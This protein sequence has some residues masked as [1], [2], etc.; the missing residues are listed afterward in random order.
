[1]LPIFSL[2]GQAGRLFKPLAFTKT[3][4]MLSAALLSI[5]FAP[6]LRDLL[7]RGRIRPE[8]RPPVSRFLIAV[9]T[10]LVYVALPRP[11][12]TV[13]IGLCAMVSAVPLALTLGHE[14]MPPLDE[15]DLLYMPITFPGISIEQAKTEL[16]RQDRILHGFPEGGSVVGKAGRAERPTDPAPITMVE[17]TVRLRPKAEWRKKRVPRWYSSW[18]PG[19]VKSVLAPVWPEARTISREELVAEMNRHL[20][21]P[22]WTNAWTMPIKTRVDMLSTGIRT[23]IGVKI[24]GTDLAEIEKVGTTLERLLPPIRGTRSVIHE[25][26]LG[27][28]YLDIIPDRDPIARHGRTVG[29]V[30]RTIEAA[31][32]GNPIGVTIEGRN[33]FTV[34]V[35]YPQDL[36][37]DVDRLKRVVVGASA[38]L[39]QLADVRIVGGPPMLRDEGGLLTGYVYIDIDP[40]E[41][42]IGGRAADT[43]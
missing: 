29:D 14:F 32:G 38:P 30:E 2:T 40:D 21:I 37:D 8:S 13:A 11:Q 7:I 16:Q 42:D 15:G 24:Y 26:N 27:G 12:T 3:F 35:R 1:F 23:P 34:N 25:R 22:G 41:R 18:A 33:R 4:V 9:Y 28:L 39:G 10:P 6:A 31:I 20:Q 36:R 17:T 19:F 5:T 43:P